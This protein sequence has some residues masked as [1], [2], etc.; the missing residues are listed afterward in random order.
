MCVIN[1]VCVFWTGTST[2]VVLFLA[3]YGFVTMLPHQ[4]VQSCCSLLSSVRVCWDISSVL[5]CK[6][7]LL[8]ADSIWM[9][10]TGGRCVTCLYMLAV[11]YTLSVL[12]TAN[13]LWMVFIYDR[14]FIADAALL[15]LWKKLNRQLSVMGMSLGIGMWSPSSL[16]LK[17]REGITLITVSCDS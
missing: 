15:P 10:I 4:N 2:S 11:Q 14:L 12:L 8:S 3:P 9:W 13:S 17:P 5:V 7:A 6:H 16:T 1:F